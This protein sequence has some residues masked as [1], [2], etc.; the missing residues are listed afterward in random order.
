VELAEAEMAMS[1]ERP[2][3]QFLGQA[4]CLAVTGFGFLGIGGIAARGDAPEEP[5]SLR[6]VAAFPASPGEVE[7]TVSEPDRF[8]EAADDQV[9]FAYRNGK[10]GLATPP[11]RI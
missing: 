9:T 4:L 11:F 8:L 10:T 6:L 1:L 5:E 7:G 3:L 2:H